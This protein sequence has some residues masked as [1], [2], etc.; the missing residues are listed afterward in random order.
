MSRSSDNSDQ[1][2]ANELLAEVAIVSSKW[3]Q[4]ELNLTV[5]LA[6]TL[7]C[8]YH[9]AHAVLGTVT[10]NKVRRDMIRNCA[11]ATF[12]SQ[13]HIKE[14][15]KILSRVARGGK[16]RNAIAHGLLVAQS[17]YANK[18]MV[19]QS[20]PNAGPFTHYYT[21]HSLADLRRISSDFD[22]LAGD[23]FNVAQKSRKARRQPWRGTRL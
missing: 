10:A 18:L 7:K 13:S 1:L 2:R 21:L 6:C 17:E 12:E 8:R 23:I 16:R 9:Q 15:E 14:I 4:I 20:S 3:A 5:L 11:L 19:M 22:I